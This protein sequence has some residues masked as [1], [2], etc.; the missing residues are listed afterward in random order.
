MQIPGPPHSRKQER[1]GGATLRAERQSFTVGS[2]PSHCG[3]SASSPFRGKWPVPPSSE[4]VPG[5]TMDPGPSPFHLRAVPWDPVVKKGAAGRPACTHSRALGGGGSCGAPSRT[6][7]AHQHSPFAAEW[8]PSMEK[9]PP[10]TPP[11]H[12]QEPPADILTPSEPSKP[13]REG[14]LDEEACLAALLQPKG[15]G[16]RPRKQNHPK[17]APGRECDAQTSEDPHGENLKTQLK[18]FVD[19]ENAT[20]CK[21]LFCPATNRLQLFRFPR[22][23]GNGNPYWP[24]L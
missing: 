11:V 9:S 3:P 10:Q 6:E 21:H 24:C 23:W 4:A 13:G 8:G 1:W 7:N 17:L 22:G 15:S 12:F 5:S 19:E 20:C 18:S 2:A 16:S 14:F